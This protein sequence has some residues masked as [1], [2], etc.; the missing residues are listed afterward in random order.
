MNKP[1]DPDKLTAT[2]VNV[3]ALKHRVQVA[4]DQIETAMARLR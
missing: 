3:P 1:V 2:P 4:S